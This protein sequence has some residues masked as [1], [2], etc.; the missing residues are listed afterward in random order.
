MKVVGF[1]FAKYDRIILVGSAGSGKSWL[2]TRIAERIGYPL[3]H[4]DKEFWLPNWVMTPNP[5]KIVRTGEMVSGE[6][7]IIDGNYDGT[8][9]LRFA[10][11]D[12]I[13]F[14]DINRIVCILSAAR[15]AGR[16]RPD[17]PD[18]LQESPLWSRDF[19]EFATW[20]WNFPR[21]GRPTILQLQAKYPEKRFIHL[22]T[23]RQV[24]QLL[25]SDC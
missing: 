23:R 3:F 11:A 24:R 9:E 5:E 20:I 4:L 22:K 8:M 13:V 21:D 15:R 1:D 14:L 19:R 25:D 16:K 17:L 6:Q 18:Y 12:L 10:A 7:W 2:A